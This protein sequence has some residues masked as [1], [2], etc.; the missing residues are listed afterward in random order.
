M[1]YSRYALHAARRRVR[2]ARWHGR[3][4][5]QS[6]EHGMAVSDGRTCMA[7]ACMHRIAHGRLLTV[8]GDHDLAL[9]DQTLLSLAICPWEFGSLQWRMNEHHT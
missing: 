7:V 8:G 2:N 3:D 5:R 1:P 9:Q 4:T 6:V